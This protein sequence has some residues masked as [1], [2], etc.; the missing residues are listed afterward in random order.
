MLMAP[1]ANV[2]FPYISVPESPNLQ[3]DNDDFF[4]DDDVFPENGADMDIVGG[5][6]NN[7]FNFTTDDYE[8]SGFAGGGFGGDGGSRYLQEVS[9]VFGMELALIDCSFQVSFN[10]CPS[11]GQYQDMLEFVTLYLFILINWTCPLV[12]SDT[13]NNTVEAA[14]VANFGAKLNLNRGIFQENIVKVSFRVISNRVCECPSWLIQ[15]SSL[16]PL[17][18]CHPHFRE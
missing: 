11:H 3:L 6:A 2:N 13:K 16:T 15:T 12:S 18:F 7:G 17:S 14:L 1:G 10:Y 8:Y 9:V 4:E 5:N